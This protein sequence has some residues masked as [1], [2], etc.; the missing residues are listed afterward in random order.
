M[1]GAPTL[2]SFLTR[3]MSL[4]AWRRGGMLERELAIFRALAARGW[5]VHLVSFGGRA[6]R[7]LA[8]PEI[9]LHVNALR[10]PT[11][12]YLRWLARRLRSL[13]G[14]AVVRSNQVRGAEL[15]AAFAR[16]LGLP[17]V[18]R[19]G[20][21]PSLF[22]TWAHGENSPEA[23]TDLALER[24]V[25]GA[26]DRVFVSTPALASR[27]RDACE[28]DADRVTVIPNFVE[29]DRFAPGGEAGHGQRIVFVGRLEPQKNLSLLLEAM[30]GERWALHVIGAGPLRDALEREARERG[31][32]A[33]FEGNVGH[34]DLPARLREAGVFC[35]PSRYEG[36]PKALLEAMSCGLAAVATDVAGSRDV[37]E[38]GRNGVLCKP[39]PE[40][41]RAALRS[42]IEDPQ[43]RAALG[44]AARAFVVEHC[45]LDRVVEREIV[46]LDTL[47]SA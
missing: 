37:I 47:R 30:E 14:A 28:V 36:H 42:V 17:F 26:A 18:A 6:D 27:V 32:D 40:A 22:S 25:F 24:E 39:E 23:Q 38:D 4:E 10:L 16:R 43:R 34:G 21:L 46:V 45:S 2:V 29:T 12:L 44:A 3:G 35:L 33:T 5:T 11:G 31:V 9:R 7:A 41:L 1:S 15:A 20:Y 8:P 13:R 19:C